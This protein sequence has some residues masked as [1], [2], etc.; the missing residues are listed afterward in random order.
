MQLCLGL[1]VFHSMVLK[2]IKCPVAHRQHLNNTVPQLLL[3]KNT[4]LPNPLF[5][6]LGFFCFQDIVIGTPGRMKDL[7]EMG[8]CNLN[9]VSF[10]V[11]QLCFLLCCSCCLSYGVHTIYILFSHKYLCG[12]LDINRLTQLQLQSLFI[13]SFVLDILKLCGLAVRKLCY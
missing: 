6:F 2:A 8:F 3:C 12:V 4:L 10:V 9:E 1:S 11:S 7:I 5:I 13:C